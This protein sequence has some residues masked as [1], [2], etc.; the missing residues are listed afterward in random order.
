MRRRLTT[1]TARAIRIGILSQRLPFTVTTYP[2]GGSSTVIDSARWEAD[3]E[4]YRRMSGRRAALAARARQR[5]R[6][7]AAV[8]RRQSAPASPGMW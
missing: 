3:T 6:R 8:V 4:A 1:S 5:T 2:Q 7:F